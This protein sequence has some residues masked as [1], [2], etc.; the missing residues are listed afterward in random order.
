MIDIRS[1]TADYL[2]EK[3]D[4]P[5]KQTAW[6]FENKILDEH[7]CRKVL[8]AHEYKKQLKTGKTKTDIKVLLSDRYC[9]SYS[10]VEKYIYQI[11]NGSLET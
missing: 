8:I 7:V 4:I 9:I 5:R 3:Q 2:Q 6:M 1:K 10:M 11:L